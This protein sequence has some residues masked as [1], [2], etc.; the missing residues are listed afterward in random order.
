[1]SVWCSAT[2]CTRCAGIIHFVQAMAFELEA[3][4]L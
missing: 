3:K 2:F 4:P 1:L